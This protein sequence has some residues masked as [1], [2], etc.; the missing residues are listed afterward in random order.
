[1]DSIFIETKL[2]DFEKNVL[3]CFKENKPLDFLQI[4]NYC[5]KISLPNTDITESLFL[6]FEIVEIHI[7][8]NS[9]LDNFFLDFSYDC[10]AAYGLDSYVITLKGEKALL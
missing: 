9:L 10:C 2:N 8:I 6:S 3:R 5:R 4:L 7:A 1:M